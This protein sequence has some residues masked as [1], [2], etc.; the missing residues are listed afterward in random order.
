MSLAN[1][2]RADRV[3]SGILPEFFDRVDRTSPSTTSDEFIYSFREDA[4]LVQVIAAIIRV[5]YTDTSKADI[6]SVYRV[7]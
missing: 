2:K 6:Q 4:T 3:F 5:N 1:Q 7:I